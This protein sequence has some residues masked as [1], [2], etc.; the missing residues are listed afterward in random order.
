[1]SAPTTAPRTRRAGRAALAA[2][3]A[4]AVATLAACTVG[5]KEDP[6]LGPDPSVST[7]SAGPSASPSPTESSASPSPSGT[8]AGFTLEDQQSDDWPELGADL[9][10]G[11]ESRVGKHEGYDRVVYEFTGK[12]APNYRVRYVDEP[13]GD[14]SGE[15][16]KV[17][18][19]VW[20]EVVV[21]SLDI[22]GESAPSPDDPLPSTLAGTGVAEANAIWGGFEGYGQAFIGLTGEQRP[23]K[24]STATNPSRLVVDV[25]R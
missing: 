18:G 12:D 4:L 8:L 2:T 21:N 9:G 17:A 25:A 10:I 1:M 6:P 14:P 15:R 19:D 16:V 3:T 23:F 13:I 24:V 5:G 11:L 22:P 20:L 7:S